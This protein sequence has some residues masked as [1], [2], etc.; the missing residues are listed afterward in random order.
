M[1]RGNFDQEI[2][3][4]DRRDEIGALSR[5]IERMTRSLRLAMERL[6]RTDGG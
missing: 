6:T 1:S 4:T 3:G 2:P 5:A